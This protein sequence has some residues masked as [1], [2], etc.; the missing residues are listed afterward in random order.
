VTMERS[1]RA[2]VGRP[3]I[4]REWP[5]AHAVAM[6]AFLERD[7]TTPRRAIPRALAGS[8]P[9]CASWLNPHQ[10]ALAQYPDDDAARRATANSPR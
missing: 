1:R 6:S 7:R 8:A 10:R 9:G 5:N 3:T 2:G 4:Y